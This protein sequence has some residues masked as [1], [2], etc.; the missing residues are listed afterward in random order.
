MKL[1][2]LTKIYTGYSFR[3]QIKNEPD[4]SIKVIQ[5]KDVNKHKGILFD[6][7]IRISNFNPRNDHYYLK[8]G[9]II[10]VNKGYN[11]H[12][13]SIPITIGKAIAINSFLII[14]VVSQKIISEY[15][16]WFL[17][18]QRVQQYF[19]SVSAGTNI[20]NVS[21]SALENIDV[22]V[23]PIDQQK[24]IARIEKLKTKEINLME[25]LKTK[26]EL[27]VNMLLQKSIDNIPK[28]INKEEMR[29]NL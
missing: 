25:E 22:I 16:T 8:P 18:S 19:Q 9:D 20:P 17:N 29:E 10:F 7:L 3:E 15:L 6:K 4:G 27:Y 26:K 1:K 11:L 5:M 28:T 21:I 13:Y 23:P 14:K 12:A 24:L 2:N